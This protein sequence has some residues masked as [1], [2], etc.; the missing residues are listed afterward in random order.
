LTNAGDKAVTVD[1]A[2]DGLW[3]DVRIKDQSRESKRVSAD[4]VEWSVPVPA[5]GSATVT[6]TFDSRW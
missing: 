1:L 5:N 2:Q 3:G 4:R 6:A